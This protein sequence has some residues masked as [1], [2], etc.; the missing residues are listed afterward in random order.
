G[1]SLYS[2]NGQRQQDNN[3]TVDGVDSNILL[4]NS[5][6]GSPP[7]DSIQEFK[8]LN[9]TSAEFGRSSGANVN[10]AIK[11]GTR[12]LHGS[13]YEYFRNDALDANDFFNNKTGVGKLPFRQNQYGVAA[14]GPVIAPKLYNGREKTFWFF[15]WEGFRERQGRTQISTSPIEAQ[16]E[17]D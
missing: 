9:N 12:D 3:Y 4:M 14:G 17:G 13:A 5:P 8:V 6:G 10:I 1:T 15:N 7:M 11:S 2:V 16:R